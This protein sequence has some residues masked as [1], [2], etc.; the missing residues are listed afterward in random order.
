[1]RPLSLLLVVAVNVLFGIGDETT[2]RRSGLC[3]Q[4]EDEPIDMCTCVI[5]RVRNLSG[6][7]HYIPARQHNQSAP[8]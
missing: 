1:M 4:A 8:S 7:T 6:G 3:E 2:A 5:K